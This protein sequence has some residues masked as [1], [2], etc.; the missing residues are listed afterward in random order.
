MNLVG[1]HGDTDA[2][3]VEPGH[4]KTVASGG[5]MVIINWVFMILLFK[6]LLAIASG[7]VL[8]AL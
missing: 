1:I 2:A 6:T 8:L 5:A 4:I 7:F 3:A